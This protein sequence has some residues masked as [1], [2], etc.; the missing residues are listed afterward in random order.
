MG[1]FDAMALV[2]ALFDG[3]KRARS[4]VAEDDAE[5]AN[6]ERRLGRGVTV[7][8]GAVG[9]VFRRD[10]RWCGWGRQRHGCGLHVWLLPSLSSG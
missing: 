8:P 2:D 5:R 3:V 4:D 7:P 6:D 10:A 1:G 9:P